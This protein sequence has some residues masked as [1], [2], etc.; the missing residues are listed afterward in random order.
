MNFVNGGFIFFIIVLLSLFKVL[1][2]DMVVNWGIM[3]GVS[4][5]N[6][7]VVSVFKERLWVGKVE[8]M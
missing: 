2:Y 6:K 1:I 8:V 7:S 4:V 3:D 5:V